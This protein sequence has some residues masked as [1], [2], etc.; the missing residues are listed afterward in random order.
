MKMTTTIDK[1]IRFSRPSYTHATSSKVV[2][3]DGEGERFVCIAEYAGVQ[4]YG[5]YPGNDFMDGKESE[6]ACIS[7]AMTSAKADLLK[8]LDDETR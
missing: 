3:R 1:D 5:I 8:K 6:A 7:G 2:G 4:G